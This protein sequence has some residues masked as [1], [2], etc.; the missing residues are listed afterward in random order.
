M[1][2]PASIAFPP[3]AVG[4]TS[5]VLAGLLLLVLLVGNAG[6]YVAC[7]RGVVASRRLLVGVLLAIDA[8]GTLALIDALA[9]GGRGAALTLTVLL[10]PPAL[11]L[12]VLS[13]ASRR[14]R[15]DGD[16]GGE[17]GGGGGGGRGPQDPG[18]PPWWP[19]FE[20]EFRRYAAQARP[21]TPARSARTAVGG[22]P[23]V[24]S[25]PRA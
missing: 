6:V 12:F 2:V 21:R 20:R 15:D 14:R 10:L 24:R 7:E 13:L 18:G 16:E 3:P 9:N 22:P 25:G 17:E 8:L 1:P 11:A 23:P 4:A 19:E 5:W